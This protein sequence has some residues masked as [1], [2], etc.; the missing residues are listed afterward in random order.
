MS[1]IKVVKTTKIRTKASRPRGGS[2]K[3]KKK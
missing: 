3:K 2:T 1:K